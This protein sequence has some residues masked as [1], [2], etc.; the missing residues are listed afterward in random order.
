MRLQPGDSVSLPQAPYLHLFV[1]RGRA[2][3]EGAGALE[4]GDAVR[5][6]NADGRQLT[7]SE[8]TELLI[9]EMH[10]RLGG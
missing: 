10:T 1:P 8:P 3:M 5:F 9:W 2:I 7:A 6:T 4:Q